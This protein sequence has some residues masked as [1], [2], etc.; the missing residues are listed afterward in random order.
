M[1]QT[2]Q[3]V[4]S[5]SGHQ[6]CLINESMQLEVTLPGGQ[7]QECRFIDNDDEFRRINS[8]PFF[9]QQRDEMENSF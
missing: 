2:M 3:I 9:D 1:I 8:T 4:K 5:L 6:N 7:F